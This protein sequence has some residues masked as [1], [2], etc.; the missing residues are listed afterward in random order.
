MKNVV[1]VTAKGGN[2]LI[3]NKNVVPILG[4]P[5]VLYPIRAA[6]LSFRTERIYVSTEDALI[7]NLSQK[8]GAEIIDRPAE[9]SQPDSLHKDV[10][11]HAVEHIQR[12]H[13]AVDNV[14]VLLGNTVMILPAIIDRAFAMLES[15]EAD[16]V[17]SAWKAQDDHPYRALRIN[18]EGYVESYLNVQC[19]SNRNSYPTAYFYDQGIWAFKARCALEQ[20]GPPPWVWLGNKCRLIERPW[21]TG[22]DI[23]TWIDV[24]ASAWYLTA[25]QANDLNDYREPLKEAS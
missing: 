21:V 16:S 14:V 22:R 11:R 19:G 20:K 10:I 18:D 5:V 1:I 7:K 23:H 6:K 8:E 3:K 24:S 9:L 25:I 2:S 17:V 15:G 4:V 13:G 12:L